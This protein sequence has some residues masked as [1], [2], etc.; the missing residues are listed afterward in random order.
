MR[1]KIFKVKLRYLGAGILLL[2]CFQ[3]CSRFQGSN[4][5]SSASSNLPDATAEER[6]GKAVYDQY[7]LQCHGSLDSSILRDK[8]IEEIS[9]A[10]AQIPEMGFMSGLNSQP[11]TLEALATYLGA[12]KLCPSHSREWDA[13]R[14]TTTQV[15][16]SLLDI[17]GVKVD[18]KDLPVDGLRG[19]FANNLELQFNMGTLESYFN[20]LDDSMPALLPALKTKFLK[21]S[22]I[23]STC[24]KNGVGQFAQTAFRNA[25]S[26][27][28]MTA[29]YD[30]YSASV[31]VG[32]TQDEA[33]EDVIEYVLVSPRF[34][35][36]FEQARPE[37]T[38]PPG[39]E[40][41]ARLA[42]LLWSSVPD[43]T[44]YDD[45]AQGKLQSAEGLRAEI[46]RM[47]KDDKGQRFFLSF[48]GTWSG[49]RAFL[50]GDY[51][52]DPL[53]SAY[54][55][56]TLLFFNDA[57]RNNVAPAGLFTADYTFLNQTLADQYQIPGTFTS[58]F[59]K[60]STAGTS[61]KGLLTQGSF[62]TTVANATFATVYKRGNHVLQH[63]LCNPTPPRPPNVEPVDPTSGD[64]LNLTDPE[65]AQLHRQTS[66]TCYAC[67]A[68]MDPIGL[69]LSMFDQ[70]A[71]LKPSYTPVPADLAT[72]P[73]GTVL[74]DP[75][76][77]AEYLGR[78]Q[79]LQSCFVD[80]LSTY[81]YAGYSS[82]ESTCVPE[83]Y[84]DKANAGP[85]ALSD[86]I[87]NLVSD[88]VLNPK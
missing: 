72:M 5:T 84:H 6:D 11:K 20:F 60:T 61:R 69:S 29:I 62:L 8:S 32:A 68:R 86:W 76:K 58:N 37:G 19:A 25:L 16:F 22:P 39:R 42:L 51:S 43:Q 71:Q 34:L 81:V 57:Y 85:V 87:L 79:H 31:A 46:D 78:G 30:I 9:L 59:V 48:M 33:L 1:R 26:S 41:A 50:A 13:A 18:T 74:G 88:S 17:L 27:T 38:A 7:C 44:L 2:V 47:L 83:A 77:L 21:C 49:E 54:Q 14:L 10:I 4:L 45:A 53:K 24:L 40:I 73:D 35:F 64:N 63:M 28:E 23:T 66:S 56:E 65:I 82:T 55:Q 12:P 3:N 67:H 70:F 80:G 52:S 15:Y 36:P 75:G